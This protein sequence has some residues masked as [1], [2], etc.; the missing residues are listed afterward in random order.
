MEHRLSRALA[1]TVGDVL[2]SY[3][4]SH[5]LIESLFRGAGAR[6]R[7]PGGNCASEVAEWLLL[8]AKTEPARSHGFLGEVLEEFLDGD[9]SRNLDDATQVLG[10]ERITRALA[11]DGLKYMRGG[12]VV[13][14]QLSA[15]AR[16]LEVAL[17]AWS[18]PEIN[19]EFE[20]AQANAQTDPPAAVT[21]ACA[22]LEALCKHY[23]AE[24]GLPLPSKQRV[25]PLWRA[26][27]KDLKV[28]PES[29]EDDDLKRILTGLASIV[30]GVGALRTHAGSAHGQGKRIYR[31]APRH[32][33]LAVHAAHSMALFMLEAWGEHRG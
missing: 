5:R 14:S 15:P 33:R 24:R 3:Y 16:A 32:A 29:V 2:G 19:T 30:D 6:C 7:S 12:R 22:L 25:A 23:L 20:R 9:V 27:A 13:S 1:T 18:I 26:V 10:R 31:I 17:Q 8:E 28:S 4:Y 11:A 21:A